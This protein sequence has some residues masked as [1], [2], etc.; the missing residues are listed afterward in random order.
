[1]K[2][3]ATAFAVFL[4]LLFAPG[5]ALGLSGEL[6]IEGTGDSQGLLRDL[7]WRFMR[8][9]ASVEVVIPESVGSTGGINALRNRQIELARTARPLTIEERRA[10]L[11]EVVFAKSPV[12][13]VVHPSV[14]EI[15]SITTE[16]V[17]DI[18]SGKVMWWE[19]L[20]GQPFKIY[21]VSREPGDSSRLVLEE[22]LQGFRDITPGA[23]VRT[24]YSTS[25]SVDMIKGHKNT[26][27]YMPMSAAYRSGLKLLKLNGVSPTVEN[28]LNGT[29]PLVL[30]LSVVHGSELSPTAK[31]FVDFLF[32]P[33]A[34]DVIKKYGGAPVKR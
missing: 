24:A 7:A 5:V 34:T 33:V 25:E 4:A 1:M 15:D 16:Q 12:V 29:Y 11:T 21:P 32:G 18:Y 27:G 28:V 31:G 20:G 17:L 9:H 19:E 2:K 30:P 8:V 6:V 10:G 13:F 23:M 22:K 26:I 14:A 3:T